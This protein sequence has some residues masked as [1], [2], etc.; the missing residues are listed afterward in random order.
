MWFVRFSKF[1]SVT[2][3]SLIKQNVPEDS[4][5]EDNL[6]KY[7]CHSDDVTRM[8]LELD[9]FEICFILQIY[10]HLRSP[11]CKISHAFNLKNQINM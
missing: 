4:V 8:P 3:Y 1:L 9:F 6:I 5:F 11:D 2:E 7:D 10:R